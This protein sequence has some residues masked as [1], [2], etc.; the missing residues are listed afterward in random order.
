MKKIVSKEKKKTKEKG[1]KF[2]FNSS[3]KKEKKNLNT[4]E[5]NE[6]KVMEESSNKAVSD[7]IVIDGDTS[8]LADLVLN[9]KSENNNEVFEEK[10][11]NIEVINDNSK[12]KKLERKKKKENEKK[13]SNERKKKKNDLNK[14]ELNER[15]IHLMKQIF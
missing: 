1:N 8:T 3:F 6:A 14:N 2:K 5:E 11:E 7:I 13:K 9:E 15:K 10:I 12:Q 4:I